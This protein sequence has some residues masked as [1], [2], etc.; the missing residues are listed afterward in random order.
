MDQINNMLTTIR[1]GQMTEKRTVST[2]YSNFKE[3]ILKI[4][5]NEGYISGFKKKDKQLSVKLKYDPSG[6]PGIDEIIS[7]S[8][9]G[10]RIYIKSS[11]IKPYKPLAGYG[12]GFG[13]IVLSTSQGVMTGEQA[14]DKKIGGQVL[15]KL[16]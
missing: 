10:R 5:K 12:K 14:R 13:T 7:V 16:S 11:Q 6:R 9:P 4:L 1:N 15:F 3:S 2:D 8:K